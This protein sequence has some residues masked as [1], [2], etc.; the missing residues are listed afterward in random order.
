LCAADLPSCCCHILR[1][2]CEA[3]SRPAL[4]K[5]CFLRIARPSYLVSCVQTSKRSTSKRPNVQ[6]SKRSTQVLG[7]K[8]DHLDRLTGFIERRHALGLE[9]KMLAAVGSAREALLR[10]E[11]VILLA[12]RCRRTL[13]GF[14]LPSCR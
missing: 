8:S 9:Q 13:F 2:S 14:A 1:I 5:S 10:M 7:E 3:E 6:T 12:P 4:P 11:G